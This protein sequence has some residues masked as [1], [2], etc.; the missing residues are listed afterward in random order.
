MMGGLF[1]CHGL[2]AGLLAPSLE[3]LPTGEG[4]IPSWGYVL[5]TQP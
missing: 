2:T 3:T 4:P 1:F 5:D